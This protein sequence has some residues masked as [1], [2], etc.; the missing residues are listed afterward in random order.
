MCRYCGCQPSPGFSHHQTTT[1]VRQF[2]EGSIYLDSR[3]AET[4]NPS[5][6]WPDLNIEQMMSC[7]L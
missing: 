2:K 4:W 5:L 1:D 7:Q 3:P 6:T